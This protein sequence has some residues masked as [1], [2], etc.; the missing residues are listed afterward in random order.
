MSVKKDYVL[1]PPYDYDVTLDLSGGKPATVFEFTLDVS[2]ENPVLELKPMSEAPKDGTDV[3]CFVRHD[4]AKTFDEEKGRLTPYGAWLESSKRVPDGLC[5]LSY[6]GGY[7]ET[8]RESGITER[9]P[10]WWFDIEDRIGYPVGW[11]G[12]VKDGDSQAL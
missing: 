11:L 8:D 1:R 12:V 9:M 5:V 3:L 10:D 2:G 6:G 4:D 7:S